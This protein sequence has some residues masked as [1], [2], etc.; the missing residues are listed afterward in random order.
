MTFSR[1]WKRN[2][3]VKDLNMGHR[4]HSPKL[5]VL[6]YMQFYARAHTDT[7][8][9]THIYIY[10]YI[11]HW[12]TLTNLSNGSV[13]S[14]NL[15]IYISFRI[16]FLCNSWR[17]GPLGA[18]YRVVDICIALHW[19]CYSLWDET[20]SLWS[21]CSPNNHL[22][23]SSRPDFKEKDYVIGFSDGFCPVIWTSFVCRMLIDKQFSC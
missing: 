23:N 18:I 9:H 21:L 8:T 14:S 17:I 7:H 13:F 2:S 4:V 3:F 10:I 20:S 19:L 5:W 15:D 1:K 12:N 22:S 11:R 6:R 16:C